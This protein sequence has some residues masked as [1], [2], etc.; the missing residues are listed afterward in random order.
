M[1]KKKIN[2]KNPHVQKRIEE[3]PVI[4]QETFDTLLIRA[5]RPSKRVPVQRG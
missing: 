5:V 3:N 4:D 2:K 1:K